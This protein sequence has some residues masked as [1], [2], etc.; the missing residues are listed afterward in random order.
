MK[1]HA[2]FVLT[3][4]LLGIA[5]G[6]RSM[7]R[8][9]TPILL[10][11]RED[12]SIASGPGPRHAFRLHRHHGPDGAGLPGRDPQG[13]GND[14]RLAGRGQIQ[15]GRDHHR[16]QRHRAQRP[17]SL[18]RM[19]NAL[20]K[21]EATDGRMVFDVTSADGKTQRKETVTIPVLGA[22]SK[23]WPL[24]CPK[25]K[26]HHRGGRRLL[27]RPD[28]IQTR[29]HSGRPGLPVPAFHRRRPISA[30]GESL[31][32][33]LSEGCQSHRRPH[34]EQRLQRDR[35]RGILPAH[36]RQIGVADHAT[37]LRR[38]EGTPEVRLRV[39]AL[40]ARTSVPAMWPAA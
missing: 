28:E 14:A 7:P 6:A 11:R 30:A 21:A 27:L 34:L 19:G 5:P 17:Q 31:L 22:Y 8:L 26:T 10:H 16:N 24:D 12:L 1:T 37:L 32:R 9:R 25:S 2:S 23:T 38:R 3:T 13:R 40:G 39:D 20:T 4:L 36:R 29:R 15:Q 33:C 18:R 35:L